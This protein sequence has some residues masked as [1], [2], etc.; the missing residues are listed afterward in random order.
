[1]NTGQ[2]AEAFIFILLEYMTT[3]EAA[4][5]WGIK[6]RRVQALCDNGKVGSA[7]RLGHIWVIPRGTPKPIDGRTKVAKNMKIGG[8]SNDE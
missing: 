4:D 6:I 1:M 3:Q 7:V 2:C 5:L 8:V